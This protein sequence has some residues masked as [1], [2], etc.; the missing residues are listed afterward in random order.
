MKILTRMLGRLTCYQCNRVF[1]PANLSCPNCGA[2]RRESTRQIA[3]RRARRAAI[4]F[5]FGGGVGA[6]CMGVLSLF[7]PDW[8]AAALAEYP[9]LQGTFG[10]ILLGLVLGGIFGA[11]FYSLIELGRDR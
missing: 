3:M 8:S 4:G 10:M 1:S 11:A 2:Q 9:A 7:W 5:V 6:I